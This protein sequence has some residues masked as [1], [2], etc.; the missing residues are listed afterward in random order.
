MSFCPSCR[1]KYSFSMRMSMHFL[2]IGILGLKRVDNWFS[3]SLTSCVWLRTL[4]IFIIRTMAAWINILRSSSICLCVA[5]CSIFSSVFSGK[6]MLMRSFLLQKIRRLE[7][8]IYPNMTKNT[9]FLNPANKEIIDSG[10]SWFSSSAVTNSLTLKSIES[11]C[12][13]LSLLIPTNKDRNIN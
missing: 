5:S 12:K 11:I 10:C 4:R 7:S 13:R 1:S 9:H 6:F 3:T 8:R 2:I